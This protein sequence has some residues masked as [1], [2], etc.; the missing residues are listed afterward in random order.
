[1][2]KSQCGSIDHLPFLFQAKLA[3]DVPDY[4]VVFRCFVQA[5]PISQESPDGLVTCAQPC[6][7]LPPNIWQHLQG[8]S[9]ANRAGRSGFAG[10]VPNDMGIVPQVSAEVENALCSPKVG[11]TTPKKKDEAAAKAQFVGM[12]RE[13]EAIVRTALMRRCVRA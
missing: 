10:L 1:M 2:S 12:S 4:F 5:N 7:P 3:T 8:K 9:H 13:S 11:T 6:P